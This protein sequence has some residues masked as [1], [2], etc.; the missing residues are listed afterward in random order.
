MDDKMLS[1]DKALELILSNTHVKN[2]SEKIDIFNC[3]GRILYNDIVSEFNVPSK[4]NSAMDGY[5]VITE[6]ISTAAKNNPVSL[7]IIDEVQAGNEFKGE[8]LQK[9]NAIRI[10]TGAPIPEGA[11]S[12]IPFEET[13][14]YSSFVKIF[15]KTEKY[16]NIRFAGEDIKKGDTVLKRGKKIDSAETGLLASM[17]LNRI[18]VYNKPEVEIISTG[19]ELAEP[20]NEYTGKIINSNAYVLYSEV[21]KYGGNPHY[22]GIVKDEYE[23]VKLKFLEVMDK[24]IIISSGGVSMG[25]YDFIP[26][27]L[28][29]IGVNIKIETVAMRPGKPVVFGTIEDKI[30]FGLPGNPVSVMVS[31]MQFVRPALLKMAG[32]IKIEKPLLKAQITENITKRKDRKYFIRGI[33]YI[34]D[35]KL[36]VTTTG[37]QGSG[38]LTSMSDSN[39][40]I[41]LPEAGDLIKTGDFVDIQLTGHNEI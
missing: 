36:L 17:N 11:D 19:N 34:K 16:E 27:V 22:S 6:D 26:D 1:V 31:F 12:V 32:C 7:K 38:I 24:D 30:F 29:D 13:E 15:K 9:N 41:V 37:P 14:E 39:C 18:D 3:H 2:Q 10:M 5:A 33:F 28:K 40:L 4:D 35:G 21:K 8:K 23:A 20:G 25:K